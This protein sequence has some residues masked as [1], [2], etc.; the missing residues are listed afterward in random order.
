MTQTTRNAVVLAALLTGFAWQAAGAQPLLSDVATDA[1]DFPDGQMIDVAICLDT[2]SSMKPLIDTTRLKLWEIVN[3]LALLEPTPRLR[4]ALLSYGNPANGHANGWVKLEAPLTEDLDL[5]SQRLFEL[6]CNGGSEYVARVLKTALDELDW[7]SSPE[8]LKLV[9]VAGN[10]SADQDPTV[11]YRAM[12]AAAAD[13]DTVLHTVFC[14]NAQHEHADGWRELALQADGQFAAIDHRT[15]RELVATPFDRELAELGDSLN[16]TYVPLGEAGGQGRANQSLQDENARSLSVAAAASR[17][18]TKA[19]SLYS[20]EW[21]LVDAVVEGRIDPYAIEPAE[22]PE[23]LREMTPAELEV[24]VE[25]MLLKR[26]EIRQRISELSAERR[27]HVTRQIEK[28][29]L[30]DSR[31][32]DGVIRRAI[33]EQIEDRGNGPSAP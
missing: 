24:Y 19:S 29:G 2:S 28:K 18:Q 20:Q 5:V 16:K 33:R 32:F 11:D 7:S 14:G 15:V 3:D 4:V 25:D 8:A 13:R 30:D 27:Q 12:G 23:P 21:D 17:A 26:Q 1:V 6:E 31:T 22:L 9:F 10:E